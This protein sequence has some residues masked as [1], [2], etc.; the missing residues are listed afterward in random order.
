MTVPSGI[1]N[2]LTGVNPTF[3]ILMNTNLLHCSVYNENCTATGAQ[4]TD[5]NIWSSSM[6]EKDMI[7]WTSCIRYEVYL[8]TR[9]QDRKAPKK[10]KPLSEI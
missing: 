2:G 1:S 6:S 8:C 3:D 10:S 4:I 9:V 7:D 5:F